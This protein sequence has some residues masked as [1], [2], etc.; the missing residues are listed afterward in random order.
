[1]VTNGKRAAEDT[2]SAEPETTTLEGVLAA[3]DEVIAANPKLDPKIAETIRASMRTDLPEALA[4]KKV[5]D[6][7]RSIVRKHG[8]RAAERASGISRFH[9]LLAIGGV[10]DNQWALNTLMM[11][12]HRG[13]E[14]DAE[15]AEKFAK[16]GASR[17]P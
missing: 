1:M 9:L 3:V 12:I 8:L 16:N 11:N 4:R 10:Q 13:D 6:Y 2:N 14:L 7:W 5:A 15:A 17:R